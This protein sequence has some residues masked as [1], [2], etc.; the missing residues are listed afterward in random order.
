MIKINLDIQ[1]NKIINILKQL[2]Q[3]YKYAGRQP[4][5]IR[6]RVLHAGANNGTLT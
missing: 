1:Y 4:V 6:S 5:N 2:I 3:P